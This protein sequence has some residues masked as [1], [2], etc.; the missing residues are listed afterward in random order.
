MGG[1]FCKNILWVDNDHADML[2]KSVAQGLPLS[3]EVFLEVLREPSVDLMERAM[4]KIFATHGEYWRIQI[5]IFHQGNH[6]TDDEAWIKRME[7]RTRPKR[8]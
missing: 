7:A 6:P 2:A 5:I 1:L 3:L 8:S 4:I